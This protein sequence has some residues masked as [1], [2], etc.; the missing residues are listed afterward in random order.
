MV[1]IMVYYTEKCIYN[2]GIWRESWDEKI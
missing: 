1:K 2:R